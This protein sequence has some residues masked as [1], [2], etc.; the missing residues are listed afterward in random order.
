MLNGQAAAVTA[1]SAAIIIKICRR[2]ATKR[3]S[4][5]VW[6]KSWLLKKTKELSHVILIR[7]LK[8]IPEDWK[9][10]WRM[11][12]ETYLDLL[13]R[14][15][16]LIEKQD[17]V[18]RSSITLHERLAA[19]L[20]FLI[21]GGPLEDLKFSTCMSAQSLGRVIPE[22]CRAIFSVLKHEYLKESANILFSI[23]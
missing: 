23:I 14:I 6:V 3:R 4:R 20:R 18:M 12:K 17:T 2:R 13:G 8:D 16:P 1:L 5:R 22:K 9:N 10:Y 7:E 15:T 21:T 19:T 11:N